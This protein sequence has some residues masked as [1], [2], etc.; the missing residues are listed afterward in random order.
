LKIG[1]GFIGLEIGD[2]IGEE[3]VSPLTGRIFLH[4]IYEQLVP[5]YFS[6]NI[7]ISSALSRNYKEFMNIMFK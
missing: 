2:W 1:K 7:H 3:R 4:P 6:I 5:S